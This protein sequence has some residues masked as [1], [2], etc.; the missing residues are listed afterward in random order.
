MGATV[1]WPLHSV[2]ALYIDSDIDSK[3]E[4]MDNY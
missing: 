2:C 4:E 1:N 3:S